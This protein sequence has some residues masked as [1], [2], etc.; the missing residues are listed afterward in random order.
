MKVITKEEKEVQARDQLKVQIN[1]AIQSMLDAKAKEY[2]WDDMKSARAGVT[3]IL[4]TDSDVVKAMKQNA[5]D[6]TEWY[7][8]VW[9]KASELEAAVE[10]GTRTVSTVDD[11]LGELPIYEEQ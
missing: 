10:A 7:Y 3:P 9:A 11:V 1:S 6:L 5:M 2:R 4:E 8:Q